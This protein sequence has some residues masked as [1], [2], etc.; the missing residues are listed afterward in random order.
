MISP[1]YRFS[2]TAEA[3]PEDI[4]GKIRQVSEWWTR[5][6]AGSTER[7]DEMFTVMFGETFV[8]FVVVEQDS[9]QREVW[10]VSDCNLQWVRDKKEWR[11]TEISWELEVNGNRTTVVMTHCG[12]TP[13]AECYERCETGWNFYV[14]ESLRR[15]ITEGAGMPDTESARRPVTN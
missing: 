7:L 13:G 3:S 14:G 8:T 2:F 11:D 4:L 12:L 15:F 10:R 1:N 9:Q 6:I 5:H